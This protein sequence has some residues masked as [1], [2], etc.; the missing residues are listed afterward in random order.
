MKYEV[1]A[2]CFNY[3]EKR[4]EKF[5]IE[6]PKKCPRCNIA[7]QPLNAYALY[8]TSNGHDVLDVVWHCPNCNRTSISTYDSYLMDRQYNTKLICSFPQSM[9]NVEFYKGIEELS[10]A[11]IKI[12]HEALNAECCNLFEVAGVGY[13]KAL[14]FL[15]KDYAITRNPQD[16]EI[17]EDMA[18]ANCVV[19]YIKNPKI[20]SIVERT[21]WLGNDQ[22]HY[23]KKHIDKDLEDLK[24][25]LGLS[26]SYITMELQAD[27]AMKIQKIK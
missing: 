3:T 16:K 12:Y 24:I 11:F 6:P 26:V 4:I 19:T 18:L 17:I 2:E 21:A 22:T 1:K 27:E 15:V 23:K 25:L 7:W 13:R 9:P 8:I 14:E 10:P 20:S 5:D